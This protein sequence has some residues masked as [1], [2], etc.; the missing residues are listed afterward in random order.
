MGLSRSAFYR[1]PD[2]WTVRDADVIAALA[3]LVK[4]RPSRGFWKCRKVLK[5]EG[6]PWKHKRSYRVYCALGL[7]LRSAA[8]ERLPKRE[9]VPL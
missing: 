9:R 7:H 2:E 5:R 8:K 1:V 3:K 4:D 6:Q